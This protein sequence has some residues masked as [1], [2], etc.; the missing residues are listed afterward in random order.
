MLLPI[1]PVVHE[2]CILVRF[3]DPIAWLVLITLGL[4]QTHLLRRPALVVVRNCLIVE[5][6]RIEVYE[7]LTRMLLSILSI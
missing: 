7:R 6:L 2:D 3:A 1:K 5:A 4:L